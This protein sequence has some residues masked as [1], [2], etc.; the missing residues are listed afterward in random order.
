LDNVSLSRSSDI[1]TSTLLRA[2]VAEKI[3]ILRPGP[4]VFEYA[5]LA[6]EFGAL[7]LV[8]KLNYGVLNPFADQ[9]AALDIS[10][11]KHRCEHF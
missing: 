5:V 11:R 6:E 9:L 8:R 7:A 2:G 4:R 3:L 10:R 1:T